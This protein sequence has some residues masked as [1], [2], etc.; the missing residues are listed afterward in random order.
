M[1]LFL[2]ADARLSRADAGREAVWEL[3]LAGG[4]P[5]AV[6][7]DTSF[8]LLAKQMRVFAAFQR[9]ERMIHNPADFFTQPRIEQIHPNYAKVSFSPWETWQVE[10]E[11]RIPFGNGLAG[12][13]TMT[14]DGK[15]F[16]NHGLILSAQME[17]IA[18]G[19]AMAV[20]QA[21][22]TRLLFGKL[23][24]LCIACV[25][26]GEI[27][28]AA[29]FY[30]GLQIQVLLQPG[31]SRSYHWALAAAATQEDALR[32]ARSLCQSNW[33]AELER[34]EM[35]H[36]SQSVAIETGN[37]AWDA[38]LMFSQNCG[39]QLLRCSS[40]QAECDTFTENRLPENRPDLTGSAMKENGR[41]QGPSIFD[42]YHL[43][44][45]IPGADVVLRRVLGSFVEEISR[46]AA[47]QQSPG[48]RPA[49]RNIIVPPLLAGMAMLLAGG[50]DE[51]GWLTALYP[52]MLQNFLDWFSPQ[53]D[54]DEDAWPEWP[55]ESMACMQDHPLVSSHQGGGQ[56]F[57]IQWL[58]SPDLASMLYHEGNCLIEIA[59]RIEAQQTVTTIKEMLTRLKGELA[60][61]IVSNRGTIGYRDAVA[62]TKPKGLLLA[63]GRGNGRI[64]ISK[65]IMPESRLMFKVKSA[66]GTIRPVRLL[67]HGRSGKKKVEDYV[68]HL[69]FAWHNDIGMATSNRTLD[70]LGW[71]KV[72]G[73]VPKDSLA[74][75]LP[76][77]SIEDLRQFLPLWAGLLS[78][79]Q[80]I[81]AFDQLK[82]KYLSTAGL[83][84]FPSRV[85]RRDAR[86]TSLLWNTFIME[87]ILQNGGRRMAA[88]I[89]KRLLNT[90]SAS[91]RIHGSFYEKYR[92]GARS[93]SGQKGYVTGLAPV[94]LFLKVIG[95]E[96]L[97]GN[98]IWVKDINPFPLPVVVQ[99]K[100]MKIVRE[101]DVTT[102]IFPDGQTVTVRGKDLHHISAPLA[103]KKGEE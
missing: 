24:T 5:P 27:K 30:P 68:S 90:I 39:F 83:S 82:T 97:R 12:R 99:Y 7:L 51:T 59:N 16:Q 74:I 17:P 25:L 14:N 84:E 18:A 100:G 79:K 31:E 54:V 101:K 67:L 58:E 22:M 102:V 1:Q 94:G 53:H 60:S 32:N 41:G 85:G 64:R 91:L 44:S 98:E 6:S 26:A 63:R 28:P 29:W 72:E 78:D 36:A 77:L 45:V 48:E 56:G 87:G 55:N 65:Q 10:E 95:I 93:G 47:E 34:I 21:G 66:D 103:E 4:N 23:D 62:H 71:C 57:D 40:D 42:A 35:L 15:L 92:T 96:R 46:G 89:M 38:A 86:T 49:R 20:S 11:F 80:S 33:Q 75:R 13:V 61:E 81:A 52:C 73:L 43:S 3:K 8:G 2:A 69:R 19:R 50:D 37:K 88:G 70:H 76:D 9:G